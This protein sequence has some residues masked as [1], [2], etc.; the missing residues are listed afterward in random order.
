MSDSSDETRSRYAHFL[1]IPTRWMG[2]NAY[3]H[4][5]DVVYYQNGRRVTRG[6]YGGRPV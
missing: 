6:C 1:A 2:N 4:V 5:N 3:G